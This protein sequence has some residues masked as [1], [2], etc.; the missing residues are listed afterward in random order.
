[1]LDTHVTTRFSNNQI[2]NCL[3]FSHHVITKNRSKRKCQNFVYLRVS[4]NIFFGNDL[5]K[6]LLKKLLNF[7]GGRSARVPYHFC[8]NPERFGRDYIYST[9]SVW[10]YRLP[11]GKLSFCQRAKL[12]IKSLYA[13]F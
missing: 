4:P 13:L 7:I 3:Q 2:S 12:G 6:K 8:H 1:M 11:Y 5:W 9:L 10:A